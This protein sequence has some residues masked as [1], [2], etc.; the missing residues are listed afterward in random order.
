MQVRTR[1]AP[2]P[3]GEYH[4]GHI[5]TL[6]YNYAFAKKHKGSFIIRIEDTDQKRLVKGAKDKILKV[7]KDYGFDWDEGPKKGG[8][9]GP[10]IQTQRLDIYKKYAQQL[11][12]EGKAYYCF[13]SSKRLDKMR[14]EQ[15]KR[16]ELPK[17]D[18]RCLSLSKEEIEKK[19]RNGESYVIRMKIPDNRIIEWEDVI[20]GKIKVPSKDIDDQVLIKSDGI[21]T[22]HFAVVID[23]HLMKI[24]HIMRGQSWIPSAPKQALLYEFFGWQ[25]PVFVHLTVLMDPDGKG[26]MSKRHGSVFAKSFLD[27]GYLAEALLN[28]L[29]LLGWNPGTN[30]EFFSLDEF[31]KIFSLEKL[32]KS[33][34]T[35]DRKKLNY[36]NKHYIQEKSNED[37]AKLLKKFLPQV[38]LKILIELSPLVKERITKLS[39]VVELT[40]FLFKPIDYPVE[41]L[42]QRGADKKLVKEM[43][44]GAIEVLVNLT[45]WGETK[46]TQEKLLK[47]IK[48]NGWNVG[49]FFMIFRVA[50][51]GQKI[52]PPIIDCLKILG[53]EKCLK[54]LKKATEI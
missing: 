43:M 3:T 39:E 8:P 52:T 12:D 9:Y 41:M 2:S 7:I 47:L 48:D 32:H 33:P 26:K 36:F 53:K 42:L 4:I 30:Q 5:R 18:R 54:R 6:L 28:F 49:Q 22:Y 25:A 21:P 13:C 23:D 27:E 34:A 38:S 24:S 15:K 1:M 35:F 37:L 40:K 31:I 19:I 29:M 46:I 14:Q 20:R 51:S 50:L 44:S 16:G 17:Y 10:Y 11:I 45:E